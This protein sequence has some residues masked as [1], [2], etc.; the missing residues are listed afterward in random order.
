MGAPPPEGSSPWHQDLPGA[1]PSAGLPRDLRTGNGREGRGPARR[2]TAAGPDRMTPWLW[3]PVALSTTLLVLFA[4]VVNR[5]QAQALRIGE[6]SSRVKALEQSR[7]LERT[8]V[9]EQQL[10][11]ML[12]RLQDQERQ[13]KQQEQLARQLLNLQQELQRWQ[14]TVNRPIIPLEPDPEVGRPARS[15]SETPATP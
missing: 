15:L 9:L 13:N 11:A 3:L 5:Q 12:T 6:L 8:A 14:S 4:V 10:R 7:A 2:R 1:G